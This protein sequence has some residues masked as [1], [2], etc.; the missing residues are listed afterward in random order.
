MAKRNVYKGNAIVKGKGYG[1]A[2][3]IGRALQDFKIETVAHSEVIKE[4]D[5][6]ERVREEVKEFYRDYREGLDDSDTGKSEN[7]ILKIY[8]HI[9]DDPAFKGQVID[10]ITRKNFSV[11]SAIRSV[12]KEFIDKFNSAGTQYFRDR[13][14]DMVEICEKL[15]SH[16]NPN[17]QKKIDFNDD[18]VLIINRSFTPSDII[19]YNVDKIKAVVCVTAGMTSHAAILARSY[20][21]PVLSD[22]TN[23]HSLFM[24]NEPV[25]VDASKGEAI[26]DPT[27]D[28]VTEYREYIKSFILE[29]QKGAKRWHAPAYT[30]DGVHIS[31]L[32]NIS[33]EHDVQITEENGADGVGLVRTEYLLSERE[34]FPT[35]EEQYNYYSHI[36][37]NVHD[38]EII[39]RVMDIGGDK[40]AKFLRMPKE[41]NPFMGWRA[42]RILL[43]KTE[44]FR[45][46]L[47]AIMRAGMGKKYGIMFPMVTALSEW[48]EVKAFTEKVAQE[49]GITCPPLGILF[50]VPLA[51]LEMEIFL[52]DIDFASIGTNDLLQ[53][54]S[55]ADRNN[56]KVNYLYNPAEPAFLKILKS[57]IDSCKDRGIPISI[58]GEMAGNPVF[59]LLL[60]GM[61]LNRFSVIP[62]MVP[63]IKEIVSNLNFVEYREEVSHLL[64][65]AT[66]ES[67]TDWIDGK[68][69]EELGDIF[70]RYQLDFSAAKKRETLSE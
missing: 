2:Y 41:D 16:L 58:C 37:D 25:L 65:V 46:Q 44:L 19:N 17:H 55:A 56:N 34:E 5:E 31:V 67:I 28:E 40:A 66:L 43:E 30:K 39:I 8:E 6:F 3:F 64:S 59:T 11:E 9:I 21:I 14:S 26:T 12:S 18:V 33:F 15:V 24:P 54:L 23:L 61:G 10:F 47:R 22:L 7:S 49:M 35:E 38:K 48:R 51:I 32:A 4:L 69:Q 29:R 53:Y 20:S 50:E 1:N 36:F 60:V 42:I 27:E 70:E 13:S 62:G 45:A 63:I 57:A 68:N 52:K